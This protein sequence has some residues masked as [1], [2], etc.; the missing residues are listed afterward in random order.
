[1]S[2]IRRN[3]SSQFKLEAAQLVVDQ[4]YTVQEAADAMG[5]GLSTMGKW[6]HQLR[7]ERKGIT[8]VAGALMPEQIEIQQLKKR[9]K[10]LE[11]EKD[12]LKKATALL[13]SDTW[14]RSK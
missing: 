9:I 14:N 6:V 4:N 11:E 7:K 10:Y 3:F 13:M 1:M 8:P 5:V 12:I 2:R